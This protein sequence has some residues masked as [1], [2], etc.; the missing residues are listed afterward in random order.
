MN[1]NISN[2][3][4]LEGA[5]ASLSLL[6]VA[7]CGSVSS[8][9][10]E[11]SWVVDRFYDVRV[12]R[13]EVPGFEALPLDEKIYIYYLAQAAVAGQDIIIDQNFKYNIP[14]R[15]TLMAIM[16]GY[17]GDRTLSDWKALEAYTKRV[18]FSN[19]IHHHYLETKF[20]PD[21]SADYFA[22]VVREVLPQRSEELIETLTP[23][24]FD[25]ELYRVKNSS[26]QSSDL[27]LSSACNYYDGGVTQAE[28]TKFYEDM[29]RDNPSKASFGLNSRLVKGEDGALFEEVYKVGGRFSEQIEQIIYWLDKA[30]DYANP[31]QRRVIEL[32]VEYYKTG[33]LEAFDE[34]SIAWVQDVD[35]NVDFIN[36]FIEIY[37]D[38]LGR[39][40]SWESLVNFR[41]EE[42]SR[43]T[44][45]I[46]D[47]AQWFEDRSP[48]NPA[49]RKREVKGI[50]AKVI[51]A[52]MLGGD[53]FPSTPIGIN[54]PNAGW[55][56][57]DYG[58]KSVTIDNIIYAYAQSAADSGFSEEFYADELTR[59]LVKKYGD[60]AA[61]M[62]VDMHE[63]LGHGSGQLAEGVSE[64]A[65]G[66]YYSA[67]EE[68]RADLF[69][70]YF[71]ADFQMIDLGLIP[72]LEVARAQY[73]KYVTTGAIS[74]LSRVE[75]GHNL[76]ESHM[77]N[78]QL[79]SQWLLQNGDGCVEMTYEG[80]RHFV[81]VRN[82]QDMREKIGELLCEVQRIKSEGDYAAAQALVEGY[83]VKIDPKLHAE[84]LKRYASL[85]IEPYAGFVNPKYELVMEE[86]KIVDVAIS[87]PTTIW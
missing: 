16:E 27:V 77:R 14:I 73:I 57:R 18:W 21:F 65:L 22:E 86:G 17:K 70:L 55:I 35:S 8:D 41:N 46:A 64:S 26:D 71:I 63:C 15:N 51:N 66:S 20:S 67:L 42:A 85:E 13:Y 31:K 52:A 7:S 82:L 81:A 6:F 79:I 56:R 36:G 78:R 49:Y 44:K 37:G 19:G 84:V 87:Y 50:T 76:E 24:I 12:L 11:Q 5:I 60:I 28:A 4:C 39:K 29:E 74:Q 32:L 62:H 10:E 45:I 53:C 58:S 9:V 25:P 59:D 83:G 47:N 3:F 38:P 75:L 1:W 48:I 61:D 2:L 33:D 72:S 80:G 34:Y 23:V 68:A 40:A 30:K 69:A 43:R 54:L